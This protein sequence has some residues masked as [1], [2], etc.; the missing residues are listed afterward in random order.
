MHPRECSAQRDPILSPHTSPSSISIEISFKK[1]KEKSEKPLGSSKKLEREF[2]IRHSLETIGEEAE[3][4]RVRRDY[5]VLF[6]ESKRF[7]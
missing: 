5:F 3:D 1:G 7:N 6:L 4:R 2:R